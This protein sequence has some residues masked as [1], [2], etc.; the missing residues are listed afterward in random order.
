LGAW[1]GVRDCHRYDDAD[2]TGLLRAD[3][4]TTPDQ[5][6]AFRLRARRHSA[7]LAA[8]VNGIASGDLVRITLEQR[9]VRGAPPRSCLWQAGLDQCA[10]PEWAVTRDGDWYRLTA[11]YRVPRGVGAMTMHIY[12]DEPADTQTNESEAW[13]RGI[14]V[15][16]L[17]SL[18]VRTMPPARSLAGS[19][20]LEARPIA[21]KTSF[22]PPAPLISPRSRVGDCAR[23]DDRS[24]AASGI[25]AASFDISDPTAVRLSA[26]HHSACVSMPVLNVESGFDYELSFSAK[27]VHGAPPRA[28]LWEANVEECAPLVKVA[29]PADNDGQF[30]YRGRIDPNVSFARIYLYADAQSQPTTIKYSHLHLKL[31]VDDALLL[32]PTT[33]QTVAV[34]ELRWHQDGPDRYRVD[35]RHSS[36]QFVVALADAFSNDWKVRGLPPGAHV[37]HLEIDGYRNAW[38]IDARGDMNLTIEYAPARAGHA[39]MRVSQLSLLALIG[40]IAVPRLR[41]TRRRRAAERRRREERVGPRRVQVPE[42]WLLPSDR[43]GTDPRGHQP[44]ITL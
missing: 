29:A 16:R 12:A 20:H 10:K 38:A 39:A 19:L 9:A 30:R 37:E 34:P 35:V 40:S 25:S 26:R 28:C 17:V 31:I 13:Y 27:T 18:D 7:C 3:T 14:S 43:S 41:K 5:R 11:T 33:V 32:R 36:G 22:A 8:P 21:V 44:T 24:L 1:S 6:S 15:N 23:S 4:V 42:A 2:P